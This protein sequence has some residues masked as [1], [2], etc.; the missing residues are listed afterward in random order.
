MRFAIST[1]L[2]FLFLVAPVS[3]SSTDKAKVLIILDSSGSMWGQ[4]GGQAKTTIAKEAL[5]GIIDS[6]PA[7]LETGLM[8]YGHR[9]KGD[10]QDIELLIPPG[11]HDPVAMKRKIADLSAKGKTPLSD[12]LR[13]GAKTMRS[14]EEAAS[15]ILITDGLETCDSDPCQVAAELAMSGVDFKVHVIGFD[16]SKADQDRVRCIADKTGGMFVAANDASALRS[17]LTD[18]VTKV[19]EPPPPVVED[20]GSA[21]LDAPQQVVV[22]E[23]FDVKWQGPDSRSDYIC[24]AIRDPK[25]SSCLDH[26]YTE[27]GNPAKLAARCDAGDFELR[28]VHGH[29]GKVLGRRIIKVLPA[30]VE[31]DV[32][33]EADAATPVTIGWQGPAYDTDYIAIA[34]SEP[35]DHGYTAYTYTRQGNPLKVQA[36]SQPGR[37]EVRYYLGAG[38]KVL[39]RKN[40]QIKEVSASITGPDK[41]DA[42]SSIT[43]EW[44]GPGNSG[45]YISIARPEDQDG[46]DNYA[47]T[48]K[49][50]TV[51]L[52]G[53]SQAGAWEVRYVLGQDGVILARR[54]IEITRVSAQVQPP[55][56]VDAASGFSV[57]WQGPNNDG[58]YIS[59]AKSEDDGGGYLS[60]AYTGTGNPVKLVAPS[61]PGTYEVR[62]IQN[63]DNVILAR[64]QLVVKGVTA[65]LQAPPS[66]PMG[67]SIEVKWQGPARDGDYIS[68]AKPEDDGGGYLYYQYTSDGNP[69]KLQLPSRAGSYEIRYI[70]AQDNTI[71]SRH[72]L[73]VD[74]VPVDVTG[75]G[76]AA[77][78]TDICVSWHGPDAPNDFISIA[79][80]DSD[81]GSYLAYEYTGKGNPVSITTPEQPGMF[82]IRY[83]SAEH[84]EILATAPLIVK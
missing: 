74:A 34:N 36:P 39:G 79:A 58:D 57:Q 68:I 6:L 21:T 76:S 19:K 27:Q 77:A 10:C 13:I 80:I 31:L 65:T 55:A 24:L 52:N 59:I 56:E 4:I 3:G 82:E 37:Y 30:Q 84:G 43:I 28:Y 45:D 20:P 9:R 44:Q 83:V 70:L 1:I 25:V 50:N 23:N 46:Y 22:G 15:V 60:Y 12:S 62:Y 18:T 32:P 2:L 16:L 78:A 71:L 63:L 41:A 14:T 11:P 51:R 72:A 48:E 8:S 5:T 38:D 75:P 53:P 42:A 81:G 67:G 69:L 33:P 49:G 47:Y 54:P 66:A 26:G 64:Q 40:I 7:G 29:S 61:A 17:A 73:T 35:P